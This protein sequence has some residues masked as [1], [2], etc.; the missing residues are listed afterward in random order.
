MPDGS[1]PSSLTPKVNDALID[2]AWSEP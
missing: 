1:T 2:I